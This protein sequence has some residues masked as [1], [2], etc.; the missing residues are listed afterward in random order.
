M[1][2]PSKT[3]STIVLGSG[4]TGY[5]RWARSSQQIGAYYAAPK[6]PTTPGRAPGT[7]ALIGRANRASAAMRVLGS[8]MGYD[9]NPPPPVKRK[10]HLFTARGVK[11][12]RSPPRAPRSEER[13]LVEELEEERVQVVPLGAHLDRRCCRQPH[14]CPHLEA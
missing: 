13:A 9:T 4:E 7:A 8:T 11:R 12:R 3:A 2:S 5:D 1:G 10:S 6:K 14:A